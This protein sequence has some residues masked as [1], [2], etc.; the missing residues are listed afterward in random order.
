MHTHQLASLNMFEMY[1]HK[2]NKRTLQKYYILDSDKENLR[3]LYL[4]IYFTR[5]GLLPQSFCKLL[6]SVYF[7][8]KFLLTC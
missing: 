8:S 7:T 2:I 5:E 6:P 3:L 1:E 4:I